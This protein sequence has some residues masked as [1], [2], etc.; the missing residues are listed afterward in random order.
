M[1]SFPPDA[2]RKGGQASAEVHRRAAH[3]FYAPIIPVALELR[4]SGLSLRA[5]ARELGRRGIR[6]RYEYQN[7]TATQVRRVL[8]RAVAGLF[9][10]VHAT[11]RIPDQAGAIPDQ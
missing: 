11:D 2:H 6:T 9:S 8:A 3:E 4:A 1:P 10:G 7:W 5:I